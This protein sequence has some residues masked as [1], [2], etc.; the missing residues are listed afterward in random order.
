[1]PDCYLNIHRDIVYFIQEKESA[2]NHVGDAEVACGFAV[3]T[4]YPPAGLF[5]ALP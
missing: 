4:A 1:M 3:D 5:G 2:P